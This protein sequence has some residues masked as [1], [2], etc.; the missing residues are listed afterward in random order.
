MLLMLRR[1]AVFVAVVGAL[2]AAPSC[3]GWYEPGEGVNPNP[4]PWIQVDNRSW[5]DLTVYISTGASPRR[6]CRVRALTTERCK[7]PISVRG[8]GGDLRFAA[9][10]RLEGIFMEFAPISPDPGFSVVFMKILPS[11]ETS[12]IEGWR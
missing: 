6:V 1:V 4:S 9:G 8:T 7:L 11:L 10:S 12:Y 2:V 3:T 5:Y